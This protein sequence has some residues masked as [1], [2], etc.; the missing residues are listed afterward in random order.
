MEQIFQFKIGLGYAPDIMITMEIPM[1][2]HDRISQYIGDGQ[3]ARFEFG[4]H[5]QETHTH[6]KVHRHFSYA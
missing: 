1:D 2:L 3:M 6:T 5:F 4:F